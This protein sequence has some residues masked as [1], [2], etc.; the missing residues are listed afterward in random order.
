MNNTTV[1]VAT[2]NIVLGEGVH[3]ALTV[4]IGTALPM[5][6]LFELVIIVKAPSINDIRI[7]GGGG[8]VQSR[9]SLGDFYLRR[10]TSMQVYMSILSFL[11]P[12]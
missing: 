12:S 7:E 5:G 10:G 11:F 9:L 6:V 1:T 2:G 3:T 8:L 4:V